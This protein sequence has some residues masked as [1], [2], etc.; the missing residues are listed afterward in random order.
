MYILF[1]YIIKAKKFAEPALVTL[2]KPYSYHGLQSLQGRI[3]GLLLQYLSDSEGALAQR[4]W[5]AFFL[6]TSIS[7]MKSIEM[8]T[9]VILEFWLARQCIQEDI[10]HCKV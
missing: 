10:Q 2:H 6:D 7:I 5:L 3:S 8:C 4:V 1:A 9:A